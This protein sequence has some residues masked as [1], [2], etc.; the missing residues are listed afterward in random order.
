[1]PRRAVPRQQSLP[2][3]EAPA[4]CALLCA[5][6]RPLERRSRPADQLALSAQFASSRPLHLRSRTRFAT[7][8]KRLVNRELRRGGARA[9]HVASRLPFAAVEAG[10]L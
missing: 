2:P 10:P 8:R 5:G 6:A 9:R 7:C 4:P 3:P 1:M